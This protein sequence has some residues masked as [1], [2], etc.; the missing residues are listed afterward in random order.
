MLLVFL[1]PQST[2]KYFHLF[3]FLGAKKL[4][5]TNIARYTLKRFLVFTER[6]WS[7]DFGGDQEFLVFLKFYAVKPCKFPYSICTG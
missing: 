5:N 2:S 3:Y 4:W 1:S 7:E 6:S